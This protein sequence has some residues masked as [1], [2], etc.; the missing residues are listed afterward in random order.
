MGMSY[1]IYI[2]NFLEG[3]YLSSLNVIMV[4]NKEETWCG[5][6]CLLD[7]RRL[8]RKGIFQE[9]EQQDTEFRFR[10]EVIGDMWHWRFRIMAD[11][12]EEKWFRNEDS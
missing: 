12:G 3:Y 1:L 8:N 10:F 7:S 9:Y 4:V 2:S 11:V 5:F 6:R